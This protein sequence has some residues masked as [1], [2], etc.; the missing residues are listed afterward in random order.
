[1]E[2]EMKDFDRALNTF[3]QALEIE[4]KINNVE[5]I[6]NLLNNIGVNFYEKGNTTKHW[7]IRAV[8]AV[9]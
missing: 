4:R 7:N 6:A 5:G 3:N 8:D 9:V 1:M 2:A